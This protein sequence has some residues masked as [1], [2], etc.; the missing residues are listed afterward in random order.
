MRPGIKLEDHTV[1]GLRSQRP[2]V[3]RRATQK[4]IPS[5]A[6]AGPGGAGAPLPARYG[7]LSA[8]SAG[9]RLGG[10]AGRSRPGPGQG[11]GAGP[12]GPLRARRRRRP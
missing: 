11:P 10:A 9:P 2:G 6:P 5:P 1:R 8:H 7:T 3:P 4:P 12:A